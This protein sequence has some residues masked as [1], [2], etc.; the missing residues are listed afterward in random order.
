MRKAKKQQFHT[1][2]LK[3]SLITVFVF[4]LLL[5]S[6][7]YIKI[8]SFI[9]E[10]KETSIQLRMEQISYEL[11]TEFNN[12]YDTT[13]NLK[14]N[15]IVIRYIDELSGS[16]ISPSEKYYQHAGFEDYLNTIRQNNKLIENIL[17][18]TPTTQYSSD[19]KFVDFKLNG[20]KVK[21]EVENNFYFINMGE[22]S[23]KIELPSFNEEGAA[24]LNDLN[25]HMFFG[26]NIMSPDG[27]HKGVILVFINPNSLDESLFYAG[28]I[29]LF[30]QNGRQFFKGDQVEGE[31]LKELN[32]QSKKELLQSGE[33]KGFYYS[34][35]PYYN[36]QLIYE[37]PL[38]FYIKQIGLMWKMIVITFVCSALA[39]I[40]FSRM[41]GRK[42]IQ[43]LYRLIESIKEYEEGRNSSS[44][45]Q[46]N[47]MTG[48]K[49][50]IRERFFFYFVI[51]VLLPL[52]IFIGILYA[53]TSKL[54]SGD[55]QENYHS[56][57]EKMA[58]LMINEINQREL[59]MARIA[60][61]NNIQLHMIEHD[62]EKIGQ[63]LVDRRQ[64]LELRR[65][66]IKMYDESG[67]IL[68]SNTH[69]QQNKLAS[70]FMST[71]T[72]SGRKISYT[73]ERDR[74]DNVTIVIGMPIFSPVEFSK[75]IGFITVDIENNQLE[76][77]YSDWQKTGLEM[78]LADKRNMILSH[79]NP[80][81]IGKVFDSKE[82][83]LHAEGSKVHA[84]STKIT[85]LDWEFIS[86]YNYSD[87]QKQVNQLFIGDLYLFFFII[88]L[89]L[90]FAYWI[91]KRMHRPI[92]QLNELVRT[93]DLKGSH[94]DVIERLSGIE[95]VDSLTKNFNQMMER[96]EELIHER[97]ITNQERVQLKY[98]KRELQ[99]NAL[100][101]QINPHFLY[102]TLDNLIYLVEAN[103]TDR[104]TEMI[105]SLSRFFR[106]ITNREQFMISLRDELSFTKTYLKIMSYRFDNF[107]SI[108]DV[109]E[110]VL[111]HKTV[112]L[113]LQPVIENAIHHGA[114]K[115]KDMVTIHISCKL[116]KDEIH[117]VV[118]DNAVG[119]GEEKLTLIKRQLAAT[120]LDKAGIYNVNGRIRLQYGEKY[121]L[122]IESERGNGTKV[123]IVLPAVK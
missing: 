83:M 61:N 109:D 60:H 17:I 38:S 51:T 16:K 4:L 65:Q 78:L 100:Q 54:V 92:G 80:L 39:A 56:V 75:I 87:I 85:G 49:L 11:Q 6:L 66:N 48:M 63:E 31:K 59:T 43:P 82:K 102:N 96:I 47:K 114:R 69:T 27:V 26:T 115:T 44:L 35:I 20:M 106:F 46:Q 120:S 105:A 123:T 34:S 103:E 116:K 76:T 81:Q 9:E 107:E 95:E 104:A 40:I 122:S 13:N 25:N 108:W 24:D 113:I 74:F 97:I 121:G 1:F 58:R 42:V 10:K 12:I 22:A 117:I 72:S 67:K 14:T 70:E 57:H 86:T 99:L 29:R 77:Y 73:L 53:Q 79:P 36:F 111:N 55:M 71:L 89:L 5:S 84:Y 110:N 23:R 62:T 88:L 118:V 94:R 64:F 90:V 19:Q 50:S 101:S 15:E 37:E 93:F 18:I 33:D 28:Q 52:L 21:T 68:Y 41:I 112:K 8:K 32:S 7:Y 119:I 2:L 98:E 30:D 3:F 91:S 45:V